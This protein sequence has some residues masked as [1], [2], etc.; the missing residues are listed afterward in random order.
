MAAPRQDANETRDQ[1]PTPR[2]LLKARRFGQV[3]QSR[4]LTSAVSLTV[5]LAA[6]A[7]LLPSASGQVVDLWRAAL[8][9]LGRA[10]REAALG[11]ALHAGG[12]MLLASATVLLLAAAA[13]ALAARMQTGPV[14]SAEPLKPQWANLNPAANFKRLFSL[15]SLVHFAL[16]LLKLAVVAAGVALI[17]WHTLGDAVRMVLGGTGAGLAVFGQAVGWTVAWAVV[18]FLAVGAIDFAYQRWQ[19]RKDMS[20]SVR[21]MRR[22]LKED[23]G[24][25]IIKSARRRAGKEPPLHAQLQF[26]PMA[27][28]VLADADGRVVAVFWAPRR[29]PRPVFVIRAAGSLAASVR[30]LA[31]GAGAPV[32]GHDELVRALWPAVNANH[33]VPEAFAAEVV[34][35][36]RR[37]NPRFAA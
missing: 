26:V 13:G 10:D 19:F 37:H 36:V 29:L 1:P 23:E 20:M 28:L 3:S 21:E 18:A 16:L 34:A 15:K 25:P 31:A 22:E 9:L 12:V 27:S 6:A 35:L 7:S 11:L 17:F 14:F 8:V 2:K 33:P 24:D 32:V 5:G 30:E 4:E